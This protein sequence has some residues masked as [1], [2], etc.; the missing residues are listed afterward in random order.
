MREVGLSTNQHS[1]KSTLR[2][3][4]EWSFQTYTSW[5]D[6]LVAWIW[7]SKDTDFGHGERGSFPDEGK[8]INLFSTMFRRAL[9]LTHPPVIVTLHLIKARTVLEDICDKPIR[10]Q[11]YC[12]VARLHGVREKETEDLLRK[13]QWIN[14]ARCR[15]APTVQH[16]APVI[17]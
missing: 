3:V 5:L 10:I 17:G 8:C 2:L 13:I 4:G 7:I 6:Y 15:V 11:S 1:V 16:R 14:C 9:G 12:D